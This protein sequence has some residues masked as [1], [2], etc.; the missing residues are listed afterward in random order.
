M[1]VLTSSSLN[2]SF[3]I[4]NIQWPKSVPAVKKLYIQGKLDKVCNS[5]GPRILD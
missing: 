4:I 1:A 5:I 2:F 3:A